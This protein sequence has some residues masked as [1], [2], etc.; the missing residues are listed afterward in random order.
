MP[1]LILTT[2]KEARDLVDRSNHCENV[3]SINDTSFVNFTDAQKAKIHNLMEL[4]FQDSEH[5]ELV[6]APRV[7]HIEAISVWAKLCESETALIHCNGT[8]SRS[9]AAALITMMEW[10]YGA[11]HASALVKT[12]RPNCHPNLLM[13][14]LY[15]KPDLLEAASSRFVFSKK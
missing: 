3:L 11:E 13:L 6:N 8:G 15:G 7:Q 2:A 5:P 9:V 4:N 1:M 14:K 10:G 12:M